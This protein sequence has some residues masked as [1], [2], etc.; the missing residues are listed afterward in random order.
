MT[1]SFP[2]LQDA[3]AERYTVIREI[4]RGGM[5][6]VYLARDVKHAR[7]VALKVLDPEVGN[8]LGADRFLREIRLIA[9][10]QHPHIL[11]LFDSGHVEE[12]FYYVMPVVK[13]GTLRSR[14]QQGRVL[15]IVEAVRIATD[16]ASGLDYAHRHGIIHRDIKPENILLNDGHAF[17][18]DFGVARAI[19]SAGDGTLTQTGVAVG[20]AAYMSPEQAAGESELDGRTD[21]YSLGCLLYEMLAGEAPFTGPTA[22]VVISR[23]FVE[24]PPS[25]RRLRP[26]VPDAI[27][28]ALA[29]ALS[30][31]PA[32][33]FA[34]AAHF[35]EAI[36]DQRD[37]STAPQI[38][39]PGPT[40]GSD[41][42]EVA[43]L[44]ARARQILERRDRT[45]FDTIKAD[46]DRAL[47]LDERCAEAHALVAVLHVL[48]A[49]LEASIETATDAAMRAAR[50]ALELQPGHQT[51]HAV[52]GLAFT[53]L[54][55]WQ[56]AERELQRAIDIPTPSPLTS[57]WFAIHATARARL[58][59]AQQVLTRAVQQRPTMPLR[60]ALACLLYYAREFDSAV[61]SLQTIVRDDPAAANAHVV[62]GLA[63]HAR[64]QTNEAI[65]QYERSIDVAGEM[66]PFTIAALGCTLAAAGRRTDAQGVREELDA[67]S[68]RANISPF[69]QAALCAA[70]GAIPE[71]LAALHKSYDQRDSWLLAVKVHPW[72]DV[73]R[74]EE[75]F[76]QVVCDVGL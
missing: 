14:L 53:L 1:L 76:I 65:Q 74:R 68:R 39:I 46:L 9:Q 24:E 45:Q 27:E 73:L 23:R 70:L 18:T 55:Q 72:M 50:L 4:G 41:H 33:R 42:S 48:R 8:A 34:S 40:L 22:Q 16:V 21:I 7:D 17:I 28:R 2:T 30:R 61:R 56:D 63:L 29:V 38:A 54:W 25:V 6:T 66:Q 62:L 47:A 43:M 32:D 3:L 51:A 5:A 10:L 59:D 36:A 37:D 71:A 44:C 49:D 57:H 69:Y 75:A 52:L 11:P 15:P 67:L 58:S 35:G 13:G 20:T 60:F 12:F 19:T 26:S 64:G 31:E